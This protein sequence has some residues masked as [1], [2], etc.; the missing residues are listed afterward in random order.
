MWGLK[1]KSSLVCTRTPSKL[2]TIPLN[3][4]N[5]GCVIQQDLHF[6]TTY[7]MMVKQTSTYTISIMYHFLCLTKEML[8]KAT[9]S[10][11]ESSSL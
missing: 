3:S 4:A 6:I 5:K 1:H 2:L 10:H 9:S 7:V 11:A 8:Y